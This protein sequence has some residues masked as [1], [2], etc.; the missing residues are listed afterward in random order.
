MPDTVWKNSPFLSDLARPQPNPGGGAAA[1]HGAL[2]A[3]ALLEKIL[4]LEAG[5]PAVPD[6]PLQWEARL[7][8]LQQLA[9]A[10]ASLKEEDVRA[11][12]KL[13][14]ARAAKKTGPELAAAVE[15]ALAA[16]HRI[17][18][19]ARQSLSL[20]Y[21]AG[22]HCRRH[23][24]SDLLVA[25]EFLSAALQGAGHIARA[26]L[27]LLTPVP[28]REACRRELER[29]SQEG[30]ETWEKVKNSLLARMHPKKLKD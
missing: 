18:A 3:L 9:R 17:M 27:P 5:R 22:V 24:L 11:Y 23:L 28:R 1:A 26:N 16:P 6:A 25:G 14:E 19:Q 8:D 29:E 4:R 20:L 15:I 2:L 21:W 7:S 30:A 12:E 10:L 13:A